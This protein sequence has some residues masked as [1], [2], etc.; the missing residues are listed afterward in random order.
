MLLSE[1]SETHRVHG[2]I[3]LK[4]LGH[5]AG[6]EGIGGLEIGTFKGESAQWMCEHIVTGPDSWYACIDPFTGSTEHQQ[7]GIDCSQLF[8]QTLERLSGFKNVRIEK[9]R[10]QDR[11]P[12]YIVNDIKID[13]IY[14]DG[15]HEA[16]DVLNDSCLAFGLLKIGGIL[17]WD[18]YLWEEVPGA[19]R[20]PK[21]A[22]DTFLDMWSDKITVLHKESQVIIRK[23]KD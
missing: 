11:L 22:I 8:E 3:W 1:S 16:P 13:F 7:L 20:Q 12:V 9:G 17:I 2:P 15:S 19:N 14:I 23:E 18:D 6:K 10:S 21:K 4:Y 5:L